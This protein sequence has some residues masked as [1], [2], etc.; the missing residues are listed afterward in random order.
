MRCFSRILI[1]NVHKSIIVMNPIDT[2]FSRNVFEAVQTTRSMCFI[3]SKTTRQRLVVLNPIKHCCSFFQQYF[4]LLY[5][6][7]V[8]SSCNQQ[9]KRLFSCN[10]SM[11]PRFWQEMVTYKERL[12]KIWIRTGKKQEPFSSAGKD[13]TDVAKRMK[14]FRQARGACWGCNR[15]QARENTRKSSQDSFWLCP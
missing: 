5:P 9:P 13:A 6:P 1:S 10:P 2:R 11:I 12:H 15:C 7:V 14:T 8:C 3:G 4:T